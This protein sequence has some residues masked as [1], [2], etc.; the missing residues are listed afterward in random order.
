MKT[1]LLNLLLFFAISS[2]IAQ[3]AIIVKADARL[4]D[5]F[6]QEQVAQLERENPNLVLYYNLFLSRSYEITELPFKKESID[7]YPSIPI[8]D[9]QEPAKINVLLYEFELNPDRTTL[10][11]WGKTDKLLNFMSMQDFNILYDAARKE[12]GLLN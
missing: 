9:N 12:A 2:A 5:V 1:V 8:P 11:R 3:D 6:S 4:L 10:I 7:L